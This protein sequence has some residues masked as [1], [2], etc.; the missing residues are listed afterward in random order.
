MLQNN[1]IKID[2]FIGNGV[3]SKVKKKNL[4]LGL[5]YSK[6]PAIASG[7]FTKNKSKAAPVKLSE[8]K[9]NNKING[10]IIN[11]GNANAA[12]GKK[13]FENS[14][15]IC[16]ILAKDLNIKTKNILTCSTGI[17]GKQLEMN[18]IT[19]GL[20]EVTKN[21]NYENFNLV[22][23]AIKTTDTFTKTNSTKFKMNE[24][25]IKI[26]GLAKGSGMIHPNMATMLGFVTTNVN[27]KKDILDDLLKELTDKTFNMISVDGDTSTNDTVLILSNKSAKNPVIKSKNNKNYK[28]FKDKLFM[29][30]KDLA[31]KIAKDG[32]GSTKLLT[33]NI[34]NAL[35]ENEAQKLAK[36]VV[37]SNLVKSAFYG[38]NTNWGR[39]LSSLGSVDANIDIEKINLSFLSD[40]KKIMLMKEGKPKK[41][42]LKTSKE[43]MKKDSIEININLNIGKYNA[44][45]WG[46]DLSEEYVKINAAY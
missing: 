5:I 11:S 45:A 34:K 28:I 16:K 2:G 35:K 26:N 15:K 43:I 1:L 12:T 31:I 46:C 32:E 36:A 3:H 4:D 18:K 37:S 29:V 9:I 7:V 39:I 27:I 22:A 8:K 13:G 6:K 33:V 40:S 24:S 17:I 19:K 44:T 30:L 41:Y 10:I 14:K 42:N 23:E 25:L 20:K 38:Q 21:L